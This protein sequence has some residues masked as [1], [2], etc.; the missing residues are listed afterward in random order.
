MRGLIIS[1]AVKDDGANS[2]ATALG[3]RR[4]FFM[5]DVEQ[6]KRD[7][8][9]RRAF[10]TQM[11]AAGLGAAAI[12]LLDGCSGS[13]TV[14]PKPPPTGGGNTFTDPNFPGV[15]GKDINTV[16]LNYASTLERLEADL[17]RQA[18]NVASGRAIDT[19]LDTTAPTGNSLGNYRRSVGVGTKIAANLEDAAFL[20]LV[21]F[22]YV[23]A[24]HRDFLSAALGTTYKP[25]TSTS[26]KYKFATPDGK[27]GVTL[28]DILTNILPLEETGVR[29]YLGA[30]GF[31]TDNTM[32]QTAVTIYST[33][34]R[35]SASLEYILGLDPGPRP[36]IPGVP[37]G[38][39]EVQPAS[40]TNI[41]EKYLKP[42][43]VLTA[44]SSAYFA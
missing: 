14:N 39:L 17:Y 34:C 44:A 1:I 8:H 6:L 20:Y 38:E 16:V 40:A 9:S 5:Y 11:S 30:G 37:A 31:I 24:A 22:A 29:A 12:A 32:L 7:A 21:Q 36:N 27:P 15:T 18:L 25:V 19:A 4:N 13:K 33:E 42:A 2:K 41:F 10:L 26:G 35:H 3:Q 28:S 43:T 23:E